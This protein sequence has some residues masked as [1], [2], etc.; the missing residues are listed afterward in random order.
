MTFCQCILYN[1]RPL[2]NYKRFLQCKENV[3]TSLAKLRQNTHVPQSHQMERK[4]V[5]EKFQPICNAKLNIRGFFGRSCEFFTFSL[6]LLL[7]LLFI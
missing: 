4:L 2:V 7:A 5:E 3:L 6:F 1:Y